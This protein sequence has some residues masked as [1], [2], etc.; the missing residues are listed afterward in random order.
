V[1]PF[2]SPA[3]ERRRRRSHKKESFFPEHKDAAAVNHCVLVLHRVAR[4]FLVQDTKTR[5][6]IPNEHKII[7]NPKCSEK[8]PN[9]HKNINIFL[10]KDLQNLPK[11]RFLV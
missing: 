8:I 5:K 9:G 1:F 6:N 2:S 3:F 11:L 10:S 4:F 7:K